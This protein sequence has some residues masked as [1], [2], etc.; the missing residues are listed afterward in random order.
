MS[1]SLPVVLKWS[2]PDIS[3]WIEDNGHELIT[4]SILPARGVYR[5][6][7]DRR[8]DS[9]FIQDLCGKGYRETTG[10]RQGF[11][12]L[13]ANTALQYLKS[14]QDS[15][16]PDIVGFLAPRRIDTEENLS[17]IR[18]FVR[19]YAIPLDPDDNFRHPL[20]AI[21]LREDKATKSVPSIVPLSEFRHTSEQ[22]PTRPC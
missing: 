1:P 11:G 19:A 3:V 13:L 12:T 14:L 15:E 22:R 8:N 18:G 20:R 4:I 9:F 2:N 7:I 16:R 21:T 6:N 5:L 17:R 10:T